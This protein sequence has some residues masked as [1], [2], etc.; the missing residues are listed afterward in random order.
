[1][2]KLGAWMVRQMNDIEEKIDEL[3]DDFEKSKLYKDYLRVQGKMANDEEIMS[4]INE[5]KK[6]Q[7]ISAN[8]KDKSVELKINGLYKKL[9]SYPIYQ[10][11]LIMHDE[12]EEELFMIKE[13]F[14]KYFM[15]LLSLKQFNHYF[16]LCT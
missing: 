7:K 12:I 15:D 13:I 8:N 10:S 1:M 14:D 4:I 11:Y 9:E 6:F 5:I 2:L 3:F 16:F